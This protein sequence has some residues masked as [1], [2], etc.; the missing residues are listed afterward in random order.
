MKTKNKNK[1][2]IILAIFAIIISM[3]SSFVN[4]DTSAD[5]ANSYNEAVDEYIKD[6][7]GPE[8]LLGKMQDDLEKNPN[9]KRDSI[10]YVI[11]RL[12]APGAYV[13]VVEKGVLDND[14]KLKK[15]DI[16]YKGIYGCNP[17]EPNDLLNHN[18]NIPNF[19]TGLFQKALGTFYK[20]FS[21]A[22]KTTSKAPFGLGVPAGIKDVP[23]N[24][25]QRNKTYTALEL[26]GYDLKLT[27]YNGEWDNIT[28]STKARMLSNFGIIDHTKILGSTLWESAKAGLASLIEG[29]KFESFRFINPLANALNSAV[30]SGLNVVVD[31]SELNVLALRSWKREQFNESLYNVYVLSDKD[32]LTETTQKYYRE[33]MAKMKDKSNLSTELFEA[34]SLNPKNIPPF[35]FIENLER[36]ESKEARKEAKEHN[37]KERI[38]LQKSK[39]EIEAYKNNNGNVSNDNN[40]NNTPGAPTNPGGNPP[41]EYVPNY[42]NVPKPVYYTREEQLKELWAEEK[43]VKPLLKLARKHSLIPKTKNFTTYEDLINVWTEKWE[44]YKTEVFSAHGEVVEDLLKKSDKDVYLENPLLDSR[45]AISHYVCA[46]DYGNPI[47]EKD[48]SFRYLYTTTDPNKSSRLNPACKPA[49]QPIGGGYFGDGWHTDRSIDTRHISE[50]PDPSDRFLYNMFQGAFRSLNSFIAKTTNVVLGLSFEPILQKLGI[51]VM[52]GEVVNSFRDTIFFPMSVLIGAIGAL[53]LFFQVIKTGNALSV[54]MSILTTFLIFVIGATFL[55][56]PQATINLADNWP[57]KIDNFV[58][59]LSTSKKGS[60]YCSTGNDK[61]GIRSAQCNIW[62]SM[63]FNPWVQLQFGTSYDNLY[64][65]GKAPDGANEMENSDKNAHLVGDASVDLGNGKVVN[66]W[67]LY[68]LSKTKS[69]TITTHNYSNFERLNAVDKDLYRIVDLQAGPNNGQG[70]DSRFFE[71]WSGSGISSANLGTMILTTI[72]AI[73]TSIVVLILGYKKIESSFIFA[74][75]LVFLPL[76]L[77]YSLMPKGKI[78]LKEYMGTMLGLFG[79]RVIVTLTLSIY[80]SVIS[81]IGSSTETLASSALIIIVISI[82]FLLYQ[83]EL[84]DAIIGTG[85]NA[86][87]ST[88]KEAT[89]KAIPL[90]VKQKALMA[91]ASIKGTAAGFVGGFVGTSSYNKNLLQEEERIR[92]EIEELKENPESNKYRIEDLEADVSRIEKVKETNK[93]VSR[94]KQALDGSSNASSIIGRRQ[95][96]K[97]RRSGYSIPRIVSNAKDEVSREGQER[98]V[99]N[100]ETIAKDV[101]TDSLS[102]NDETKQIKSSSKKLSRKNLKTLLDPK[103]QRKVRAEAEKREKMARD[104][105][106]DNVL[107][108]DDLDLTKLSELIEKTKKKDTA[109]DRIFDRRSY[110][111]EMKDNKAHGD[112]SKITSDIEEIVEQIEQSQKD[113]IEKEKGEDD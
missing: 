60:S 98:I 65:K 15:E 28:V 42:K 51:D 4:L 84:I 31:T 25:S 112:T 68:Q 6:V 37:K 66:N 103:V 13:N 9:P 26:F 102:I 29:F 19:T 50:M 69:G 58:L 63:V 40:A 62:G 89:A 107:S 14:L 82:M 73:T 101:Y 83:Q 5:E 48:G 91:K 94:F 21:N 18:C 92:A 75:M 53:M 74:V 61:S 55:L 80:L 36:P 110:K 20:P 77:L 11:K 52:V 16:L 3:F 88:M 104:E 106:L 86:L 7:D 23:I 105:K 78:K 33:W 76:I 100:K 45:Q 8:E 85:G 87:K 64:A 54:L 30:S 35:D 39:D 109:K 38:K 46:D 43:D 97:I 99:E 70:T 41:E 108:K 71:S 96:R 47:R 67:A 90:S 93:T 81:R 32:V 44:P 113:K 10:L 17:N 34:N 59:D 22:E 72:Q 56:K 57:S 12:F 1:V 27:S 95:E 49:R 111:E 79:K 2:Y 24:P